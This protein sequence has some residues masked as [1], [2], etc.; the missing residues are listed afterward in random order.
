MSERMHLVIVDIVHSDQAGFIRSSY[1]RHIIDK[2][3]RMKQVMILFFADV[4]K[5]FDRIEWTYKM[6]VGKIGL[7]NK[8]NLWTEAIYNEPTAR[9]L[10]N[11]DLTEEI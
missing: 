3:T 11:G 10:I 8:L 1:L 4:E 9:H 2:A 7:G 5:A 6:V